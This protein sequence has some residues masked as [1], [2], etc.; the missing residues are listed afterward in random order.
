MQ[1]D[2]LPV[3]DEVTNATR[4]I[5][6]ARIW[7]ADGRQV[8][9]L[10]SNIWSD[11][12]NWGIMLVDLARHVSKQYSQAGHTEEDVLSRIRAVFDVEWNHPTDTL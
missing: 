7:V 8:V 3:P 12:G 4:S 11:P 2:E 6:M 1:I 10:N 5:E 9:T